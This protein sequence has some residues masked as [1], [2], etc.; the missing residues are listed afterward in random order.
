[1][2]ANA[3]RTRLRKAFAVKE[4]LAAGCRQA[5]DARRVWRR[6][7]AAGRI[8]FMERNAETAHRMA[9]ARSSTT[10]S[11]ER[12]QPAPAAPRHSRPP[13]PLLPSGPDGVHDLAM[14]RDRCGPPSTVYFTAKAGEDITAPHGVP[15]SSST[16]RR[17]GSTAPNPPSADAATCAK[18]LAVGRPRFRLHHAAG[19][20]G[21]SGLCTS[22]DCGLAATHLP[23]AAP[24]EVSEWLKE[25]A[26]KVCVR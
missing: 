23:S 19:R 9:S 7:R 15:R 17:S 13:L 2:S 21:G 1:M 16:A 18:S 11:E 6:P 5:P 22:V 8:R 20:C 25:H 24:G 4:K 12:R 10:W 26:W 3:A 14:R